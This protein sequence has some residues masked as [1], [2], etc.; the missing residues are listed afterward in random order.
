MAESGVGRVLREPGESLGNVTS[1]AV[2][3]SLRDSVPLVPYWR[4]TVSSE[5]AAGLQVPDAAHTMT[6]F[7]TTSNC[8]R[9]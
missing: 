9:I 1:A 3:S 8:V 6:F 4:T 2:V 5:W 7:L